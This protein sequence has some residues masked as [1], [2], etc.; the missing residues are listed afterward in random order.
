MRLDVAKRNEYAT[1]INESGHHLLSV[2]NG[3]LDMSKID[4]GEFV[5]RPESFAPAPVVVGCSNLFAL[6]LAEGGL[7]LRL[8]LPEDLPEIVADKRALKQVLINLVSNAIKFTDRGGYVKIAA[9]AEQGHILLSVEDNGIGISAEDMPH[10]GDQFFQARSS[11]DRPH[12]GT[13]LGLSIVKGLV[14]LHGGQLA[15]HSR[16]GEGTCV[17]LRLPLDCEA[18]RGKELGAA[19]IVHHLPV[20][21]A[22]VENPAADAVRELKVPVKRRA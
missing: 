7:E 8:D 1:L 18:A 3:I 9:R 5:L 22:T 20:E 16:P 6:K 2:V 14:G 4:T 13:G 19:K 21:P 11:Y 10:I 12:D 15:M 17:T